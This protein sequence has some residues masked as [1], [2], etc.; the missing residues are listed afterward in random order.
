MA[1][2]DIARRTSLS[3]VSRSSYLRAQVKLTPLVNRWPAWS[4]LIAPA[5]HALNLAFRHLP[6][7]KSFVANP[8]VHIAASRDPTMLGGPFVSLCAQDVDRT[9]AYME[10][11][12][13]ECAAALE[14][15]RAFRELDSKLLMSAKGFCLDDFL[16]DM[17]SILRGRLEL[18]YDLGNRARIKVFEEMLYGSELDTAH[19]Q[20]VCLQ[21]M[22][23]AER[24]FFMSAPL[25]E[26]P[27][28]MFLTM[29]FNDARIDKLAAMRVQPGS[30]REMKQEFGAG[31][32]VGEIFG[33][34]FTMEAPHRNQPQYVGDGV[35]VRYFGHA[36]LLLQTART[37]ILVDPLVA[38]ERDAQQA[39]LT[40]EDLPDFID[41]VVL[42]HAHQDHM[43]PETLLQIRH[44][45]GKVLVPCNDRGNLA[46]PSMKLILKALG[47]NDVS[48]MAPFEYVH[49]EDA[50]I[51]SLPFVGEH[52]GLDIGGKQ[53]VA[54]QA[55]GRSFVL[56]VDSDAVEQELYAAIAHRVGRVDALFIGMECHGAPL[57]WLYG[58]LLTRPLSKRDDESRRLSGSNCERAWSVVQSLDCAAV[59]VYA[60]GQEHWLTSLMGLA[61]APESVQIVESDRLVDRCRAA[62]LVAER[63]LGCKEMFF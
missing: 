32:D 18:V 9:R 14:F 26:A 61:Y 36:C 33:S 58:P 10:E 60:M 40:F 4:H 63:L 24:P 56:L 19:G 28:R 41:Y 47:F 3:E 12:E 52:A 54:I 17:P 16:S 25:F 29:D 53:C 23:D 15:A 50:Q 55:K 22:K 13:R 46:D 43:I 59:M 34:F 27:G 37:T 57:T 2:T 11:V 21:V 5:T 44:K 42:T 8:A 6:K 49:A 51:I 1:S 20:C 45:V 7:L 62:G 35:R 31:P 39:S 48:A 38:W 30:L